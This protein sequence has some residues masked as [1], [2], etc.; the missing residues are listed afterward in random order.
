MAQ[1]IRG[2]GGQ[3][4]NSWRVLSCCLDGRVGYVHDG[5]MQRRVGGVARNSIEDVQDRARSQAL[6]LEQQKSTVERPLMRLCVDVWV[7]ALTDGCEDACEGR[8]AHNCYF[9]V[10][11]HKRAR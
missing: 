6:C 7:G 8:S 11:S 9:V 4:L 5:R 2:T 3:A 1:M 10:S